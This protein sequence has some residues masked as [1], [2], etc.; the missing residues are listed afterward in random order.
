MSQNRKIDKM[1]GVKT[2]FAEIQELKEQLREK[3]A[4]INWLVEEATN[5]DRQL[6]EGNACPYTYE[7]WKKAAQEVIKKN[8]NI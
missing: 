5:M 3:E 8:G 1:E 6:C 4:M 7:D 2:F